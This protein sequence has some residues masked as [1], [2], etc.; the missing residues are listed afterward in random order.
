[1][2]AWK[3]TRA[4]LVGE[5]IAVYHHG[6]MQRDF[7]FIDDIVAGVLAALDRPPANDGTE[8]PG[9]SR[10]HAVYNLGN[11]RSDELG[12]LIDLVEAA[13]GRPAIRDHQPLQPGDVLQTYAD[14]SDAARDLGFRPSTALDAGI[15]AFVEWYRDFVAQDPARARV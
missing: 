14:V 1:M 10:P 7:T 15:P 3:F 13:C 8:K 9:G 2:A 12:R 5:P 4:I 11:H 6:R